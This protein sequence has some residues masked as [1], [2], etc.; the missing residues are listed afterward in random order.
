VTV[1]NV[2]TRSTL[3]AVG[4]DG[5]NGRLCDSIASY[6]QPLHRLEIGADEL[7]FTAR[8]SRGPL[9]VKRTPVGPLPLTVP[10]SA[11]VEIR[12]HRSGM[13]RYR[14]S[15]FEVVRAVPGP[16]REMYAVGISRA[17]ELKAHLVRAGW[18][19]HTRRYRWSVAQRAFVPY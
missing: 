14:D 3:E 2:G 11:V 10:R 5:F 8:F 6:G 4:M 13:R 15:K 9:A 18:S 17:E 1:E 16:D 12:E 19:V 7:R